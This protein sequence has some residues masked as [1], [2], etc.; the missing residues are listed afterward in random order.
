V[1]LRLAVATAL[2][3]TAL[4]CHPQAHADPPPFPNLDSFAPVRAQDFSVRLPLHPH[5]PTSTLYFVTPQGV[6]CNFLTGSVACAGNVPGV[7]PA[8]ASPFTAV[9]TANGVQAVASTPYSNGTIEG[10][11]IQPLPS[12]HSLAGGGSICGVDNTGTTAC[13]DSKRRGFVISPRGTAW[14]PNV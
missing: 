11:P 3:A 13:K 1:H 6:A 12:A 5:D 7:A 2:S 10:L 14:L 8:D 4:G 9:S